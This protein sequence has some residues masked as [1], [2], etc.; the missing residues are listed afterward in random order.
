MQ[1]DVF[2]LRSLSGGLV[3]MHREGCRMTLVAQAGSCCVRDTCLS[4]VTRKTRIVGAR[5]VN[6]STRGRQSRATTH[7]SKPGAC[8]TRHV[9]YAAS[10]RYSIRHTRD[11]VVPV[12]SWYAHRQRVGRKGKRRYPQNKCTIFVD[13]DGRCGE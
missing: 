8:R 5:E 3:M 2:L 4:A 11:R 7:A 12:D 13:R 10:C 1:E 9:R 6:V